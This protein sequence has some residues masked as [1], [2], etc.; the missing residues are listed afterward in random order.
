VSSLPKKREPADKLLK[1]LGGADRE[2]ALR[3]AYL[4]GERFEGGGAAAA[5][6]TPETERVLAGLEAVAAAPKTGA[7][8][9]KR[10]RRAI[11]KV[12]AGAGNAHGTA[13][14]AVGEDPAPSQG[15]PAD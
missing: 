14:E 4:L 9:R 11:R 13:G 10:C 5:S 1:V 8:L 3:A 12:R 6:V 15:S 7:W 2:Q